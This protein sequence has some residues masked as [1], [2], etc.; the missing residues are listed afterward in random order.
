MRDRANVHEGMDTDTGPAGTRWKNANVNAK[1]KKKNN[2]NNESES[3]KQ[4]G[5]LEG[6]RASRLGA[7]QKNLSL[8]LANRIPAR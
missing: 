6:R 5:I 2:N 8:S 7:E 4:E 1:K 3:Q